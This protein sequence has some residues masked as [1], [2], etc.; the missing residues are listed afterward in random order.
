MGATQQPLADKA[1]KNPGVKHAKNS[2]KKAD[3]GAEYIPV[4]KPKTLEE[5]IDTLNMW[6][7]YVAKWGQRVDEEFHRL[8]KLVKKSGGKAAS[9]LDPPPEPYT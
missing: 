3:G 9:H 2:K 8:E 5:A 1:D 4:P 7:Y 6:G